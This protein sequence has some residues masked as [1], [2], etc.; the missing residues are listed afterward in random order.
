MD[1]RIRD[2]KS[3]NILVFRRKYVLLTTMKKRQY[4]KIFMLVKIRTFHNIKKAMN[5]T[6]ILLFIQVDFSAKKNDIK[7]TF[8][9]VHTFLKL[10]YFS[11]IFIS[12]DPFLKSIT[13]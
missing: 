7:T 10:K 12:D 4:N 3:Y 1:Q 6:D 5:E 8:I 2:S 13:L 9:L 11:R